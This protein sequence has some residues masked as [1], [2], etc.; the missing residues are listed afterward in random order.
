MAE[1][2]DIDC[3]ATCAM[4]PGRSFGMVAQRKAHTTLFAAII[5]IAC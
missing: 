3:T 4:S 2:S 5:L 1:Q